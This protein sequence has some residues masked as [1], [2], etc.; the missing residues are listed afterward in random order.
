MNDEIEE[1]DECEHDDH[2]DGHCLCCGEE[3]EMTWAMEHDSSD[4]DR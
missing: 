4:M 1:T 2:E 3:I